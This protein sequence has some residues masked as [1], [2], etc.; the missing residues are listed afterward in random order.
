L[1]WRRLVRPRDHQAV[2][3]RAA[4][5]L[6][7]P[8]E[9]AAAVEEAAASGEDP[10]AALPAPIDVD[11]WERRAA[12]R[13]KELMIGWSALLWSTREGAILVGAMVL[14]GVGSWWLYQGLL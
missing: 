9:M 7:A 10:R 12:A 5:P 4:V 13:R 2:F 11:A 6:L 14:L 3:F 1:G 8:A